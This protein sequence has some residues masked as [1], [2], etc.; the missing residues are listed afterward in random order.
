MRSGGLQLRLS[1]LI[2]G[3]SS[4]IRGVGDDDRIHGVN[5]PAEAITG[6]GAYLQPNLT[7]TARVNK[8]YSQ[9]FRD[10]FETTP[11][12][13]FVQFNPDRNERT[14]AP[15]G[16][17]EATKKLPHNGQEYEIESK[18]LARSMNARRGKAS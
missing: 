7:W 5:S 16:A 17:Y 8:P 12:W 2:T 11:G 3:D 18:A 13:V 1:Q 14:S 4:L 15:S 10:C 9:R 6:R